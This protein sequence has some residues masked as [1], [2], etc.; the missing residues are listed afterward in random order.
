[1]AST[2]DGFFAINSFILPNYGMD[3][4]MAY[5]YDAGSEANSESCSS[6]PGPPCSAHNARDTGE[7]EGFVYVHTGISGISDLNSHSY[8]WRGPV[9][10][11]VITKTER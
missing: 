1:M 2:N 11:I 9:A 5:A 7:A 3:H 6:V 4:V 10:S 8:D